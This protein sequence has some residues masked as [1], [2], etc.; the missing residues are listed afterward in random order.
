MSTL[1]KPFLVKT[2]VQV[3]L[4]MGVNRL[5]IFLPQEFLTVDQAQKAK[6]TRH[7]PRKTKNKQLL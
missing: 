5:E 1:T 7:L 2:Q 4:H 6:N 3:I